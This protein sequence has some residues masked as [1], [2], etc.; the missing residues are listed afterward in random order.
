MNNI[1]RFNRIIEYIEEHLTDEI[2]VVV[3]AQMANMSVYEFR[4]I[5]AFVAGISLSEYIRKRRLSA[6]AEELLLSN[7]SITAI[8]ARYGYDSPAAFSRSFKAFHNNSPTDVARGASVNMYTKI[9][10]SFCAKGGKDIPYRIIKDSAFWIVGLAGF[11]D[12]EDTECCERVWDA[13]YAD[14]ALQNSL[15]CP[16]GK[17]YAAYRNSPGGVKCFIGERAETPSETA[18]SLYIPERKW[19]CFPLNSTEDGVVNAF[20]EDIVF[21]CLE[22]DR[23]NRETENL[24]VYPRDMESDDFSWEIRI[25]LR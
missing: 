3:L 21:R 13:F 4:R 18:E 24:E 11:S 7:A 16:D 20:Y 17:I 22:S 14:E 8:A 2:D 9:D 15:I 25:P 1:N 10:F 12:D 5:F 23:Y 19:A 6:A